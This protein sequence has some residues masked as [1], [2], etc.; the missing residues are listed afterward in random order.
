VLGDFA[1]QFVVPSGSLFH[2]IEPAPGNFEIRQFQIGLDDRPYGLF[3]KGF[4]EDEDGEVYVCGSTAL[5]PVG[6]SG[7][8][9]RIV[10]VANPS[11]DIKPGSCPNPFN[12]KGH[13]VLP[14]ALAGSATF[15]AT[16]VDVSSVRLARADGIG[17][18]AAPND[19]PPGPH[20]TFDD[21]ATPFD[22]DP[23]NCHE[24]AGDGTVDLIM[25]F[26]SDDVTSALELDGL[27]SGSMVELVVTGNLV[28]G[29]PFVSS[30]DCIWIVPPNVA[31]GLVKVTSNLPGTWIDVSPQDNTL[32]LGGFADFDRG[33][34]VG[35]T[36]TLTV[37]ENQV[38]AGY[39]FRRWV[40]DGVLQPWA[41]RT[42]QVTVPVDMSARALYRQVLSP[43]G[44]GH[45][46]TALVNPTPSTGG[47]GNVAAGD[48]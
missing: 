27:P 43:G 35:Q 13:G 4:G 1:Q 11:L 28:C 41:Q 19:G 38:P 9:E 14:I 30:T 36:V 6:T 24:L 22:G 40:V 25:H 31:P 12:L 7:V 29:A 16:A 21:A 33:Y 47:D 42:I 26:R 8:V 39:T 46:G 32:D 3:L 2:L 5:A 20:S 34:L 37:Q 17:G 18:Q 44:S 48:L 15:D 10:V 23:C 45:G